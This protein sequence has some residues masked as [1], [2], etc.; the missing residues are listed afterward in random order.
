MFQIQNGGLVEP[1][2]DI[3]LNG[4]GEEQEN[5]ITVGQHHPHGKDHNGNA[6][7]GRQ[8]KIFL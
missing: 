1:Q 5:K 4:K 6:E 7:T 3:E 2:A 8:N